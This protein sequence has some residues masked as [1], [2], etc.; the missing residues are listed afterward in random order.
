MQEVW[1]KIR[2][3]KG[4]KMQHNITTI[5]KGNDVIT[6]PQLIAE[7]FASHYMQN[8]SNEKYDPA[9]E[10]YKRNCENEVIEI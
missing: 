8:L 10:E 6:S 2:K 4:S 3:I 9:F 7:T 5:I 1:E